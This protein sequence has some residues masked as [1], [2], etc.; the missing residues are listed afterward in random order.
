VE[1]FCL[2]RRDILQVVISIVFLFGVTQLSF[3]AP[4]PPSANARRLHAGMH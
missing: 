1:S 4:K 2:S 3:A